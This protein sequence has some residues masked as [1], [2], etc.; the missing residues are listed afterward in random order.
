M[1][2]LD[3]LEFIKKLDCSNM[4]KFILDLPEQ[5]RDAYAIGKSI[6]INKPAVNNIVFAGVGGSGIG[7]DLVKVYLG[8][9]LKI[10]VSICRNYTLPDFVGDRTILFC[11][12]YSGNTEETLSC[13]K[14]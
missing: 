5:C 13:F 8:D 2:K 10:P 11:S 3:N 6:N 7:P 1:N 12:S 14:Q 4:L 9:E